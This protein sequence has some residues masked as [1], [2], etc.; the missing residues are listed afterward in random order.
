MTGASCGPDAWAPPGV[1]A[2]KTGVVGLTPMFADLTF[3]R[4]SGG[5][6]YTHVSD[7]EGAQPIQVGDV[8]EVVDGEDIALPACV[9]AID[10]DGTVVARL[11]AQP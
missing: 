6:V 4:S 7:W 8:I 2:A 3:A 1:L 5:K 9:E 11:T 10:P